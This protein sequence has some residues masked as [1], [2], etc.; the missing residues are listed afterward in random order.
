M[1]DS[2]MTYL[3]T[4]TSINRLPRA[5]VQGKTRLVVGVLAVALRIIAIAFRSWRST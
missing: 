3:A 5:D 2:E 1:M 4:L